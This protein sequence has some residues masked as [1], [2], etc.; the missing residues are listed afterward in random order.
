[1]A[2]LCA[3]A[4]DLGRDWLVNLNRCGCRRGR[5]I[6][7]ISLRINEAC[8]DV[9]RPDTIASIYEERKSRKI[10]VDAPCESEESV[11]N[12]FIYL[13]RSLNKFNSELLRKVAALIL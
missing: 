10:G 11:F 12:T 5:C 8:L 13:R 9:T 1:M 7:S 4:R 2:N 3:A 6:G